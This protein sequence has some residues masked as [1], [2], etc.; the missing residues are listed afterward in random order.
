VGSGRR[1]LRKEDEVHRGRGGKGK[2]GR[3]V[4]ALKKT[5]SPSCLRPNDADLPNDLL[6]KGK[7]SSFKSYWE[8]E[9][10]EGT[11]FNVKRKEENLVVIRGER[12]TEP[13]LRTPRS[14]T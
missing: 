14:G 8:K 3:G 5:S 7:K 6:A 10:G 9:H 13:V 1:C 12:R 4:L 2:W 11:E